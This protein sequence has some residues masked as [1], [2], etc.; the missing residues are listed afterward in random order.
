MF[1]EYC[2]Q[3]G[4][5]NDAVRIWLQA[6]PMHTKHFELNCQWPQMQYEDTQDMFNVNELCVDEFGT[7]VHLLKTT[8]SGYNAAHQFRYIAFSLA[9]KPDFIYN[10]QHKL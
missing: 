9:L 3:L 4:R 1:N 2:E 5:Q 7:K 6:L 10:K 8:T